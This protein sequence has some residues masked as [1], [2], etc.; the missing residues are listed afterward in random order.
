MSDSRPPEVEGVE[1]PDSDEGLA[2]KYAAFHEAVYQAWFATALEQTKAVFAISSAGVGMALTLIF[3]ST[4][5]KPIPWDSVWLVFALVSFAVSAWLCI[6]VFAVNT[7]IAAS[8]SQGSDSK[9]HE[10]YARRHHLAS[11]A[12]FG[13]GV[14]F[15]LMA[16]V[17]H[18]WL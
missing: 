3:G 12:G 2:S 9:V 16:A 18:V 14:L 15:F 1:P 7:K 6:S 5:K 4:A 17:A 10:A 13:L 11:K 8:L